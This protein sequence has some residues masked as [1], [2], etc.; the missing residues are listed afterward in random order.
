M[1]KT[2]AAGFLGLVTLL[3]AA[4]AL[5]HQVHST[6]LGDLAGAGRRSPLIAGLFTLGLASL[7]GLPPLS[8]YWSKEA[9]L[10]AAD[11][12]VLTASSFFPTRLA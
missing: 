8:G 3:P 2:L 5:A 1:K 9:V 7:A 6:A 4:G 11:D 12:G 10:G